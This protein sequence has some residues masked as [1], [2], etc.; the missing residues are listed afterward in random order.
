MQELRRQSKMAIET[1][2]NDRGADRQGQ[3]VAKE[4]A[5][6]SAVRWTWFWKKHNI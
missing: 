3:A 4:N 2:S 6:N 5:E 1:E